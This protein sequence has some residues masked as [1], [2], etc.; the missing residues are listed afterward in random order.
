[1]LNILGGD[2]L[3]TTKDV[4]KW[5][6]DRK[7]LNNIFNQSSVANYVPKLKYHAKKLKKLLESYENK[8]VDVHDIVYYT[9]LYIIIEYLT[10]DI[11]SEKVASKLI[12]AEG[13]SLEIMLERAKSVYK[14]N[15]FLFRFTKNYKPWLKSTEAMD[16][17]FVSILEEE[18]Q[19]LQLKR[20]DYG[21]KDFITVLMENHQSMYSILSHLKTFIL[22]GF[23]TTATATGFVLYEISQREDIQK[24][25][26]DEYVSIVGLKDEF[27]FDDI[28][29]M[30]YTEAVIK[31]TM[32]IYPPIPFTER[33][34]KTPI[35]ID[36]VT[37]PAD[38]DLVFSIPSLHNKN[39]SNPDEFNPE[40][41][42]KEYDNIDPY[43]YTPFS[44]GPRDCIGRRFALVEMK[45]LI[46]YIV[47][48]FSLHPVEP[49]HNVDLTGD[50]VL[51]SKN[52]LPVIFKKRI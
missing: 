50:F 52:G 29:N 45:Y 32:R 2:G 38:I 36:G 48:Y 34:L 22:A 11:I 35:D 41:F 40:R 1:M 7:L 16:N 27:T 31:E 20:D 24:N 37:I 10:G 19:K 28:Q 30:T 42:L 12:T 46:V 51:R 9:T 8:P 33:K 39:F 49:Q 47:R 26:Y 6:C 3:A 14:S 13:K 23:D 15:D 18:I 4:H 43:E 25:I 17:V 5:K 21:K 44:I